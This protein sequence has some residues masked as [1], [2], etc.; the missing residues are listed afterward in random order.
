MGILNSSPIRI[1]DDVTQ[2][3]HWLERFLA[4]KEPESSTIE[5]KRGVVLDNLKGPGEHEVLK[6]FSKDISAMANA[7]GGVIIFGIAEEEDE[8]KKKVPTHFELPSASH[9]TM[10]G[11]DQK[12][13]AHIF[14]PIDGLKIV[15][16]I[17]K[18]NMG[19]QP[20]FVFEVPQS[21]TAHQAK[22]GKYYR[23]GNATTD[24]MRDYEV[25]EVMGRLKHPDVIAQVFHIRHHDYQ[26]GNFHIKLTNRGNTF[27]RFVH[28]NLVVPLTFGGPYGAPVWEKDWKV[29]PTERGQGMELIFDNGGNP[30][31]P[32]MTLYANFVYEKGGEI[33]W[34]RP[35][36]GNLSSSIRLRLYADNAPCREEWRSLSEIEL[37]GPD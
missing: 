29:I 1:P 15:P 26:K 30:I 7:G 24:F 12:C 27:C 37:S 8:F 3:P 16:I 21:D 11:L 23:R 6:E 14:P 34:A 10:E 4:D 28:V 19:S 17:P 20:C 13:R 32:G 33:T 36:E 31:F 25:R 9:V 35:G 22:D 2:R 18:A 5:Y